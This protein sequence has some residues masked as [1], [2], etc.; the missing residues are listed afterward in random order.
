MSVSEEPFSFEIFHAEE[1]KYFL[2]N[3]LSILLI[4]KEKLSRNSIVFCDF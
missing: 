1:M 4:I 3:D 2:K